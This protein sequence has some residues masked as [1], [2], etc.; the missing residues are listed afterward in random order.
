[1]LARLAENLFWCGRYLVRAE[2]TARMVDV[3]WHM[4]LEAS[5][6]A[7][8]RSWEVLLDALHQTGA[9]H[10]WADGSELVVAIRPEEVVRWL[11]SE[12]SNP[13]SVFSATVAAR[14]NARS[15]RELVS[16]EFWESVNE[17]HLSMHARDLGQEL[18]DRP[19][20]LFRNVKQ[21]CQAITGV[22][23]ETMPRDEAYRFLQLGRSLERAE[24]TCRLVQV[25]WAEAEGD[26]SFQPW[27]TLLRSVG[28]LES[29]RKRRPGSTDPIDVVSMLVLDASL[30][31][32]VLFAL[33]RAEERLNAVG[34]VS[35]LAQRRLGRAR[36]AL[37][38]RDIDDVLEVGL[39]E[40]LEATQARIRDVTDAITQEYF[41]HMPDGAMHAVGAA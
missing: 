29:F 22:A 5:P 37:E 7:A 36:A 16:S 19:Y 20:E 2:D 4:L 40:L 35:G 1:M 10:D 14:E 25:R 13:G 17:L 32:S 18:G 12:R 8:A 21:S 3:T 11:V 6:L 38:Y 9:Y 28:A 39:D 34:S 23:I 24:M 30:P 41:R 27:G 26:P 33:H 15:V 31:R